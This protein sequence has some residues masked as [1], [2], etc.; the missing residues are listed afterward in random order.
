[1]A[2]ILHFAPTLSGATIP[3]AVYNI[4]PPA[5]YTDKLHSTIISPG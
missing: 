4:I 5:A 1:M 3:I 2:R